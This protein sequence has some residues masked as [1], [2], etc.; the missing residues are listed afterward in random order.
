MSRFN[1]RVLWY[2]I[3][4]GELVKILKLL[5]I[6]ITL[7]S[8]CTYNYLSRVFRRIKFNFVVILLKTNYVF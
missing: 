6:Y 4:F 8:L 1:C 7:Y 3:N 5:N 2:R